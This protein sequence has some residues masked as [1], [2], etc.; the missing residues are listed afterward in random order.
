MNVNKN[1]TKYTFPTTRYS[2]I[3]GIYWMTFCVINTF[4]SVYLLDKNF[5]SGQIGVTMAL[6]GI[7]SV[8]L[9]PM[10]AAAS[11]KNPKISLK[12]II[13]TQIIMTI[14]SAV[15]L[16]TTSLN[17]LGIALFYG[18]MIALLQMMTPFI[19]S[20]GMGFIN[21]GVPI[22]FGIARGMGSIFCA[23][24]AFGFGFWVTKFGTNQIPIF[25][26]LL[27]GL[28]LINVVTFR[29]KVKEIYCEEVS[30]E[31]TKKSGFFK[32]YGSFFVLLAGITG[33]FTSHNMVNNFMM[34][35]VSTL[36][37]GSQEMG[38]AMALQAMVELPTMMAFGWINRRAK[39]GTLLKI[40]GIFFTIK[41]FFTVI[42]GS[43]TAIYLSQSVQ[44]LGFALFIPASVY[45]V[46]TAI[47][48]KDR[49]KGQAFMAITAT[50]GS[51]FGSLLGGFL[52]D[53]AGVTVMLY[54]S[55]GIAVL[56]TIIIWLS[57]NES[58]D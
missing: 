47:K 55:M 44:M 18:I 40:S 39:S 5:S 38:I 24:L 28:L 8:I 51:V 26:I 50:L 31:N 27:Y 33:L 49:I 34:Q 57:V 36:G 23:A 45:Y 14:I 16:L 37:G 2:L 54:T 21:R 48:E 52:I 19:S 4:A 25:V 9:Q 1:Q 46:N 15:I 7:I 41:V 17:F 6:A 13:A 32:E 20:L 10:V 30:E 12:V 22:N 11:D 43:I 29:F 42:S 56:G 3:Q 53:L 58:I 35:I